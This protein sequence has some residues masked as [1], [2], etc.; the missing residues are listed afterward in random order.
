MSLR[1]ARSSSTLMACYEKS[2]PLLWSLTLVT[3]LK[4]NFTCCAKGGSDTKPQF[5]STIRH[6]VHSMPHFANSRNIGTLQWSN[7]FQIA[8]SKQSCWDVKCASFQR[9]GHL[10]L[11][12]YCTHEHTQLSLL[13]TRCGPLLYSLLIAAIFFSSSFVKAFFPECTSNALVQMRDAHSS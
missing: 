3:I 6:V 9:I 5:H 10:D 4:M 8:Q 2:N 12:K 1:T 11:T 13:R 7:D